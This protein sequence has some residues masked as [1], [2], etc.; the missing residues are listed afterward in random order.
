MPSWPR[1]GRPTAERRTALAIR[2]GHRVYQSATAR[3]GHRPTMTSG[4]S[5]GGSDGA[6]ESA[7]VSTGPTYRRPA[8]G[9]RCG[10]R[11][12]QERE[13]IAAPVRPAREVTWAGPRARAQ[14][15]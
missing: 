10:G 9:G 6:A 8:A 11:T 14:C 15:R 5:P 2:A 12:S 1:A 13:T 7:V 4:P 3:G